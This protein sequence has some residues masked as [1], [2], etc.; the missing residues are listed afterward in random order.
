MLPPPASDLADEWPAGSVLPG[1]VW[2]LLR[3]ARGELRLAVESIMEDLEGLSTAA[4]AAA[5]SSSNDVTASDDSESTRVDDLEPPTPT[6]AEYEQEAAAA[7]RCEDFELVDAWPDADLQT[8]AWVMVKRPTMD[9][10]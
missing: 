10:S 7:A 3:A 2:G 5:S 8:S 1:R 4:S 6:R 9:R